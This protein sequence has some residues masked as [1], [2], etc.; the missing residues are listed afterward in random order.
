MHQEFIAELTEFLD[1]EC[2]DYGLSYK[3]LEDTYGEY[4]K[5]SV[6]VHFFLHEDFKTCETFAWVEH[7]TFNNNSNNISIRY[8][9]VKKNG[10]HIEM[11]ENSWEHIK[12]YN[13]SV[14][15]FWIKVAPEL[16]G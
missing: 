1:S 11:E 4:Y 13:S 14:K 3:I 6:D 9:W 12:Y 16:W 15:Y 7:E 8:G 2:S 10:L 5:D